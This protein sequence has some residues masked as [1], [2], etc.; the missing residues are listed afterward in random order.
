M[1]LKN[2][3]KKHSDEEIKCDHC[4]VDIETFGFLEIYRFI[5]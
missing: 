1:T 2:K 4:I 3:V 5:S